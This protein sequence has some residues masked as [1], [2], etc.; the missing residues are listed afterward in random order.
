MLFKF[1]FVRRHLQVN[2]PKYSHYLINASSIL[3]AVLLFDTHFF[4]FFDY[5]GSMHSASK[6]LTWFRQL[7]V[8]NKANASKVTKFR[9]HLYVLTVR[10]PVCVWGAFRKENNLVLKNTIWDVFECVCE[11]KKCPKGKPQKASS[12]LSF[13]CDPQM[14]KKN[15][16]EEIFSHKIRRIY[17]TKK[18]KFTKINAHQNFFCIFDS[19]STLSEAF[20]LSDFLL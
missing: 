5:M 16:I 7:K 18:K 8:P 14:G 20:G 12:N 6:P 3:F 13:P 11:G 4:L 19:V 15:M 9:L 2:K 10:E 1:Y 17:L